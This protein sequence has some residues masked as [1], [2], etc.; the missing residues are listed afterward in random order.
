LLKDIAAGAGAIGEG[1]ADKTGKAGK[2]Q[3]DAVSESQVIAAD[4]KALL[5][6]KLT[7]D[8]NNHLVADIASKAGLM[9][10]ELG[11][12]ANEIGYAKHDSAA[13]R[14]GA[15]L[16]AV[17]RS[18]MHSHSAKSL[19]QLTGLLDNFHNAKGQGILD[20]VV[21]DRRADLALEPAYID[22]NTK[23]NT[24]NNVGII[25]FTDPYIK[26]R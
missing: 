7:A 18:T 13:I 5:D 12:A 3:K 16:E 14:A 8:Q 15:D 24:N 11:D 4:A 2:D 9:Q 17:V 19:H 6:G 26:A 1:L 25:E 23:D 20:N 10:K 21:S 22:A